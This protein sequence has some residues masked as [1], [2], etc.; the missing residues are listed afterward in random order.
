[1]EAKKLF[2][3][4]T[5]VTVLALTAL[6]PTAS[7]ASATDD[8]SSVSQTEVL[9]LAAALKVPAKTES[10]IGQAYL[11]L[12]DSEQVAVLQTLRAD[13]GALIEWEESTPIAAKAAVGEHAPGLSTRAA[14]GTALV[15]TDSKTAYLLGIPIGTWVIEYK[16]YAT[17]TAVTGNI[18][19]H[20]WFSG[21]G[22]SDTVKESSYVVNGRGT[23]SAR[24]TMSF[25]FKGSPIQWNKLHTFTTNSGNPRSLSGSIKSV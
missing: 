5:G 24:H 13:P 6:M 23:C 15:A 17:S 8:W 12:S 21:I 19:C 2:L 10:A 16:Y 3:T 22:V 14:R 20:G 11:S 4:F 1:M 18:D 9:E 7:F 25:V